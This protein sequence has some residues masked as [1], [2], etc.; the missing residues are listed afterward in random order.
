MPPKLYVI[1]TAAEMKAL[2]AARAAKQYSK[3]W[4]KHR[5]RYTPQSEWLQ[6]EKELLIEQDAK[7][8]LQYPPQ[9][10]VWRE[11]AAPKTPTYNW[12]DAQGYT[13]YSD[14]PRW[15]VEREAAQQ[16]KKIAANRAA[17]KL[18]LLATRRAAFEAGQ[19]R[20]EDNIAKRE[21]L[22]NFAKHDRVLKK[23]KIY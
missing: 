22:Y 23:R 5:G 7:L 9:P 1:V 4:P 11:Y 15:G 20:L 2:A 10:P 21:R 3:P 12:Q 14:K 19:K 16:R 18:R 13:V 8:R 6:I 17:A